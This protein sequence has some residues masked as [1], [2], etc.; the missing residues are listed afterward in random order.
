MMVPEPPRLEAVALKE[1]IFRHQF[2]IP[3]KPLFFMTVQ[4][5]RIVIIRIPMS[6]IQT[7]SVP[8]P[9]GVIL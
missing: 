9:I 2:E 1:L 5:M 7:G 3:S 8:H 6:N 4:V